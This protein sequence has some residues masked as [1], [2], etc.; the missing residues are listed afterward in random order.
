MID[1]DGRA[2]THPQCF[3]IGHPISFSRSPAIHGHW[4]RQHGLAGSYGVLDVAPEDL[5]AFVARIRSGEIAGCNV[6]VPLKVAI[7]PLMDD[8]TPAAEAVGAVNTVWAEKG[9]LIGDNTDVTGFMAHLHATV[10]DW[11][12]TTRNALILGA[13]GAARAVIKGLIDAGVARITLANRT[14]DTA[15]ALAD[16]FGP[17]V[18]VIAWE[19]RHAAVAT[20]DMIVNTTAL[21]L[22]GKPPLE[23]DL[24]GLRPGTIVYDIVYVPLTT[25]LLADAGMRGARLVDGLGMLLHQAVP[26]FAR[27]FGVTPSVTPALRVEIEAGLKPA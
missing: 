1:R 14:Q 4:L 23:L 20:A 5:P 24:A 19:A 21:G 18:D 27:W 2:M 8:L 3:V 22:T 12:D 11:R 6:T 26:G 10:P 9:R 25:Q 15:Q 16:L 13:G 17:R 7:L